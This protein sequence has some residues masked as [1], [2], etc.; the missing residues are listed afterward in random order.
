VDADEFTT[1][2]AT[3]DIVE[4]DEA[5]VDA[6]GE[7]STG[8]LHFVEEGPALRP[9]ALGL[10]N[11]S[12]ILHMPYDEIKRSVSQLLTQLDISTE[13]AD[14]PYPAGQPQRAIFCSRTL[15]L[16]SIQ[17]IG[18]PPIPPAPPPPP[19]PLPCR[20]AAHHAVS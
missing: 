20:P 3:V 1:L 18:E 17:A 14:S 13:A 15:N 9:S 10:R 8:D 16:R 12:D 19:P 6:F 7:L 5:Q 11:V 2:N 4:A